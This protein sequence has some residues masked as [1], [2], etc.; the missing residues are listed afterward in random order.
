MASHPAV[1]GWCPH[2]SDLCL[3]PHVATCSAC[4]FHV[5]SS[6]C[7]HTSRWVNP[8]PLD[9]V[10]EDPAPTEGHGLRFWA[11][12]NVGECLV[13]TALSEGNVSGARTDWSGPRGR[14]GAVPRISETGSRDSRDLEPDG[15]WLAVAGWGWAGRVKQ[16][17]VLLGGTVAEKRMSGDPPVLMRATTVH[18]FWVFNVDQAEP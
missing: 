11:L 18:A 5:I 13:N 16:G 6:S 4:G 14:G 17:E 3:C 12:V 10:R 9:D 8:A 15:T 1:L 7:K 2:R